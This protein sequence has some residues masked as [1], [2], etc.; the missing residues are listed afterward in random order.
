MDQNKIINKNH[1]GGL[2]SHST[3][4]VLI[5]ITDK[6]NKNYEKGKISVALATDLTAAFDL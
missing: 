2:K 1:H 5:Q 4:T 3:T 6:L